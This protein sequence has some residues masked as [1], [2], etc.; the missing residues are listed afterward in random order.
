MT[1]PLRWGILGTGWVA[2]M[3]C[4]DLVANGIT[5]G[6][7]GSRNLDTARG[8]A[9]EYRVPAAHGSYAE[10]ACDP[11]IDIVYVSSPHPFHA[12]HAELAIRTGKH[13]MVEK[14][15]TINAVEAQQLADLAAEHGVTVLEAM[16][17]RY[18]PHIVRIDEIIAAGT[19]GEVRTLIADHSQ[20]LPADPTHRLNDPALGGGALLDLGIYPVWYADHLFGPPTRVLA[21]AARTATGVDRQDA[22]VL[23]YSGGRQALLQC[24]LDTP[25]PN[26]AA[27]LG[28]SGRIAVDPVWHDT[29]AFTV[30]DADDA[31]LERFDPPINGRGMHYQAL[32]AELRI[33]GEAGPEDV[34]PATTS[35][36]VMRT[37]D[38]IRREIGLTYPGESAPGVPATVT[39]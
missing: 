12:P 11:N 22:I 7:V 19:I 4:H 32:A 39:S 25:G 6:A 18:V 35:V 30:Y 37:M 2:H 16:W 21:V 13:V 20:K 3:F 28:T 14:P 31:V 8:F 1:A 38:A 29:A 17:T 23:E 24:A 10:L 34:M 33:A 9:A 5:I 36:R 27:I 26:T 15:F